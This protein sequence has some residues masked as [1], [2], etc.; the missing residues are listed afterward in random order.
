MSTVNVLDLNIL[1]VYVKD[2]ETSVSNYSDQ[3]G[4]QQ[5][6]EMSPGVLIEAGDATLYLEA[7]RQTDRPESAGT[8]WKPADLENRRGCPLSCP[9][10]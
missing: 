9:G 7:S 5:T 8:P 4:F 3:L 10:L 1:A 2:L 6:Q